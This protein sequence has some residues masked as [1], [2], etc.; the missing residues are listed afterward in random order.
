MRSF[1]EVDALA[2]L[3]LG[4]QPL[5][6]RVVEVVAAEVRVAVGRLHLDDALADFEDRDVEGAAAEVVDG[7]GLVLLLVEAVGERRRGR[8]VD[9]AQHVEPGDL[10]R[11]PWSPG[12]AR[13]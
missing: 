13:R 8:L 11:R 7:D 2:L 1:D 12:A 3:E 10:C 9:D 6:D 4:D 5:D